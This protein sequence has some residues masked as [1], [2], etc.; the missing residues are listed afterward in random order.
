MSRK[1]IFATPC[2]DLKMFEEVC[3]F[4]LPKKECMRRSDP[5]NVKETHTDVILACDDD[6]YILLHKGST[7]LKAFE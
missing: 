7:I 2:P 3:R 5:G 4:W 6:Y 1:T